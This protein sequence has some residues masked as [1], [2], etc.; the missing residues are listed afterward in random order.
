MYQGGSK[1][2]WRLDYGEASALARI[3]AQIYVETILRQHLFPFSTAHRDIV[4]IMMNFHHKQNVMG[5]ELFETW[6]KHWERRMMPYPNKT[7]LSLCSMKHWIQIC[8]DVAGGQ[9]KYM[10]WMWIFQFHL[11]AFNIQHF[12]RGHFLLSVFQALV[13]FWKPFL[14]S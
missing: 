6:R 10:Y 2:W 1:I 11:P 4:R 7:S 14:L 5:L 8:R 9:T 3:I 13:T 12:V